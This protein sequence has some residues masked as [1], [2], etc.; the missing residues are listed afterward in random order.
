MMTLETRVEMSVLH[1][2][3]MSIR[4]IAR[5][6]SCSRKTVR[7]YIRSPLPVADIRHKPRAPRPCKLDPFKPYILERVAA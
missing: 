3:G 4:A 2:Q 5:Q 7:R 1:R 6:L